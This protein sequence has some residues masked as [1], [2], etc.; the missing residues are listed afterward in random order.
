MHPED[1]RLLRDI[2][3]AGS[4]GKA[5]KQRDGQPYDD[6]EI[7]VLRLLELRSQGLISMHPEPIRSSGGDAQYLKT[8]MCHLTLKGREALAR[9]GD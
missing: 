1:L 5:F 3:Q 8:G 9:F 4:R 6:F 7:E 2:K